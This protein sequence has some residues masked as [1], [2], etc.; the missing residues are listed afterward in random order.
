MYIE[1][2]TPK[3]FTVIE[4]IATIGI[5]LFGILGGLS[6]VTIGLRAGT[7]SVNRTI[8]THLAAE[9]LE[10]VRNIRDT[11]RI[12]IDNAVAG[13]SS[14]DWD[15]EMKTGSCA[16][17]GTACNYLAD[18]N[19]AVAGGGSICLAD[20]SNSRCLPG[21]LPVLYFDSATG[22]YAYNTWGAPAFGGAP[23]RFSRTI[24]ITHKTDASAGNATY[25]DILS[26]VSWKSGGSKQVQVETL[27][28]DWRP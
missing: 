10:L 13:Y 4:V 16:T 12:K 1:Q 2:S 3:G 9:G 5:L 20:G 25:L 27:L 19:L 7:D 23:S 15:R 14:T 28:Y 17:I 18:F 11:N 21:N 6:A 8:A 26:T 24:T 22:Q